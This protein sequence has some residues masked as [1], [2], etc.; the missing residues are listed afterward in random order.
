MRRQ[1]AQ[2]RL[3][4]GL[5]IV[6]DRLDPEAE[7]F[8]F[9]GLLSGHP[10]NLSISSKCSRPIFSK[11]YF[12]CTN[13]LAREPREMRRAGCSSRRMMAAER[14]GAPFGGARTPLF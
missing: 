11:E 5:G 1:F 2:H 3:P 8:G 6:D 12:S 14:P 10:R 13:C 7:R 4:Q 9:L